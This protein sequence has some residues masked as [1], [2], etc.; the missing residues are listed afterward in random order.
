ME[1]EGRDRLTASRGHPTSLFK[2]KVRI[3]GHGV[4]KGSVGTIWSDN[5]VRELSAIAG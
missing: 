3:N 2:E 4:V 5:D 1:Y